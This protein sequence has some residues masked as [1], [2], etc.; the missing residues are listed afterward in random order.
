MRVRS[1]E[2]Q[3]SDGLRAAKSTLDTPRLP[4]VAA[5]FSTLQIKSSLTTTDFSSVGVRRAISLSQA[6]DDSCRVVH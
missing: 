4:P 2:Q 6:I 1:S 5:R 3:A